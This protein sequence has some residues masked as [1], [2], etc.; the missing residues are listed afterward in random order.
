MFNKTNGFVVSCGGFQKAG[1]QAENAPFLFTIFR[2]PFCGQGGTISGEIKTHTPIPVLS[3]S[4][5][6]EEAVLFRITVL[7]PGIVQE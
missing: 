2:L 1:K 6:H 3:G 7:T 5:S 4:C